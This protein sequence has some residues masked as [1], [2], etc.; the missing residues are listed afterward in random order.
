MLKKIRLTRY[1]LVTNNDALSN[2]EDN[3]RRC[4]GSAQT[5]SLNAWEHTIPSV[6]KMCERVERFAIYIVKASFSHRA[7][8]TTFSNTYLYDVDFSFVMELEP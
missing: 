1:F 4:G 7:D 6:D 8:S 3:V 5:I 2:L